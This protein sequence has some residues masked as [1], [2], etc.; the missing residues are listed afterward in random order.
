MFMSG[1]ILGYLNKSEKIADT[2]LGKMMMQEWDKYKLS[3]VDKIYHNNLFMACGIINVTR[4]DKYEKLPY[5]DARNACIITADAILDN[6]LELIEILCGDEVFNDSITDSSLILKA[7]IKWGKDCLKYL[8]G[9]FAFVIWDDT[10]Q[11]LFCARDH[12]GKRCLYYYENK[13]VFAFS[14]T[15]KPLVNLL[16]DGK[17]EKEWIADF[18]Y[19]EGPRV[20]ING[21]STIYKN[22]LKVLPA[23]YLI[24]NKDGGI[25]HRKYWDPLKIEKIK[26]KSNKEYIYEFNNIFNEAVK[27][28]L[29]CDKNIAV[30][31][32]GGLDSTSV[33]CIAAKELKS[34][35][36]EIKAYTSIP[37]S[38]YKNNLSKWEVADEREYIKAVLDEN[39]NV[40]IKY[41][42][43]EEKNA[44]SD[45][46]Y[47]LNLLEEPY[48]IFQ[49]IGWL[50]EITKSAAND[51]CGV[52]LD[53]QFGNS[54]ISFGRYEIHV[55]TLFR[56][57]K[58]I[59]ILR[60]I[61]ALSKI[62][63]KDFI[64]CTRVTA[65]M[66]LKDETLK[67][68]K[69]SYKGKEEYKSPIPMKDEILKKYR[70]K[71]R[72]KATGLYDYENRYDIFQHRI[73]ILDATQF[74]QV[75]ELETKQSLMHGI[76]RRDPTRDKRVLEFCLNIPSE[77][78]VNK[79]RERILIREA[80]KGII[81]EKIRLN[82]D[83]RGSQSADWIQKME[84]NWCEIFEKMSLLLQNNKL[85]QY[86]DEKE[87]EE[88][89]L[90][91]KDVPKDENSVEISSVTT[92]Y[93]LNE[94]LNKNSNL[95]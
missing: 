10:N 94:F 84:L 38:K 27:C 67:K 34:R 50:D 88:I 46:D 28:R 72:F 79:G 11:E 68:I 25:I 86:I 53:G 1:A 26:F 7:Y 65:K 2:Y 51:G 58:W 48:K 21:E 69:R 23:H 16:S 45:V 55:V 5:Y 15:I 71:D 62:Y 54:S 83:I 82:Y 8:I 40:S 92:L 74:N 32:S 85:A 75:G 17:I 14:T 77:Q 63:K 12:V 66:T 36:E 76:L 30:M 49:N 70:V 18:L 41:I 59:K 91:I 6:R 81:P 89:I 47:Y 61:R 39:H 80:M 9:D 37:F 44:Y 3:R 19:L 73:K 22:I 60:E 24:V 4:E 78:Y 13:D 33:A 31:M 93:I 29:R 42:S 87:L 64:T 56:Q 90:E 20:G 95:S 57:L 43:C 35:D 52:I